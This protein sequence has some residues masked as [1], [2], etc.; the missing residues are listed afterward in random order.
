MS[1]ASK[2][3]SRNKE[4]LGKMSE[5]E[6]K[7]GLL[8]QDGT[9]LRQENRRL[10]EEREELSRQVERQRKVIEEVQRQLESV[11]EDR[12]ELQA[13]HTQLTKSHT[14][15]Q[16]EVARLQEERGLLEEDKGRQDR[17]FYKMKAEFEAAE[18]ASRQLRQDNEILCDEL[19]KHKDLLDRLEKQNQIMTDVQLQDY[20]NLEKKVEKISDEFRYQK[21]ENAYLKQNEQ[22]LLLE[23]EDYQKNI[24]YLGQ[25]L[26]DY[27]QRNKALQRQVE[28]IDAKLKELLL[29]K[30]SQLRTKP[31]T[32]V[33]S[34][35]KVRVS[36]SYPQS[37]EN[38]ENLIRKQKNQSTISL[39]SDSSLSD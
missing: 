4:I 7:L 34:K 16:Y 12:K 11:V 10:E 23:I 39:S 13:S 21:D 18:E 17:L 38:L 29:E 19:R 26:A 22:K 3:K 36:S 32:T 15:Q 6:Q 8:A 24:D 20:E 5:M 37:I 14:E 31:L 25:S 27:K 30:N 2:Q 9:K 35:L 33:A 28:Q 1:E